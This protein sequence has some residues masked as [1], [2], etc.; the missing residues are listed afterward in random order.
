MP[1]LFSSDVLMP[2]GYC[3]QW[4]P[5]LVWLHLTSDLLIAFAYTTIPFTLV[6]FIR[7]R[8]DVPFRWIFLWFGLFIVSC[9]GTHVF[10]AWNL[11]HADYWLAGLG[12]AFT[13]VASLA[14]AFLLVRV[15]P[16]AI[17]LPSPE[18]LRRANDD[19]RRANE[20]IER[21]SE[22]I[23]SIF[24]H[25]AVGMAV[26]GL[27]GRFA[28]VNPALCA[29]LGYSE[30]ELLVT[31]FQSVSH[32][33]DLRTEVDLIQ[34]ML[35]GEVPSFTIGKRYVRKD[36]DVVS[37]HTSVTLVRDLDGNPRNM[38]AVVQDVTG[39]QRTQEAL[40]D[41]RRHLS[42][43]FE[44]ALDAIVVF[45]NEGRYVDA[46]PA[47]GDLLG[48]SRN[49]LLS[50]KISD[51]TPPGERE[52]M[53]DDWRGFRERGRFSDE[54]QL[55][56]KDGSLREVEFRSVANILPGIHLGMGRD[57]TDR[58]RMEEEREALLGRLVTLQ[59]EERRAIS[60]ELHDE[61]G[62]LL[63]GLKLMLESPD[64]SGAVD[65][66]E[67]MK[68]VVNDLIGRV[69]DLSMSLRPPMLDELGVLPTLLWQIGR[70]E[71]QAG[72]AVDFQH[73]NLGRRFPPDVELTAVRV[74]QEALTNVAKHA[75]VAGVRVEV[76]A[77]DQT[78]G[79]RIEDQ[80][81]GFNVPTAL[82]GRSSGLLGIRERCRLL[83]GRLTVES[84]PG[85]GTR[86]LVELPLGER[87]GAELQP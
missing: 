33:D 34:R 35:G 21:R 10:E 54:Y 63:T 12:K 72:L 85:S 73:A 83:H 27:D 13:A 69:R 55:Q 22:H 4:K 77:N 46:N 48:Y 43:L 53:P 23:R 49:E 14:T 84:T 67:E 15:M 62:Q 50:M 42:A 7:K 1:E 87:T 9:G 58:K 18:A 37:A 47:A 3:Y 2:H 28:Q 5:G 24:A 32:P 74:V 80:G 39:Y 29:M 68:R 11:Y 59:E 52:N 79:A 86:L 30:A 19:L 64:V 45:D 60:R 51:V 17:A 40:S 70:F 38:V 25:T 75:G 44:N 76:W 66:R 26:R 61:V 6:Y 41:S 57:V 56:C 20:E 71:K 81:R 82:G 78:L 65:R 8:K 31:D 36:G 16:E